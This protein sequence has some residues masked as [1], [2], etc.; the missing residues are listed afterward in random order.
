MIVASGI[1]TPTSMTVVETSMTIFHILNACIT[2]SFSLGL[3]FPWRSQIFQSISGNRSCISSNVVWADWT[4]SSVSESSISGVTIKIFSFFLILSNI[5]GLSLWVSCGVMIFVWMGSLQEGIWSIMLTSNSP[6]NAIAIDLGIG[7]AD[8][9]RMCG[10]LNCLKK[11]L[12]FTQNLCCSSMMTYW[13]LWKWISSWRSAWVPMM[14]SIFPD[15][16]SDFIFSFIDFDRDPVRHSI[17]NQ[18]GSKTFAKER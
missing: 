18:R 1:S 13:R 15:A 11:A 14:I 10:A 6:K 8:I 2:A 4:S 9:W 12:C 3:S 16:R 5:R 17:L 7:V